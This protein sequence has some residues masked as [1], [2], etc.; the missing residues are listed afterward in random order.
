MK[1]FLFTLAALLMAGS[2]FADTYFYVAPFDVTT[3]QVGT[4]ITVP[5]AAH[6]DQAINAGTIYFTM[7]EGLVLRRIEQ[8]ADLNNLTYTDDWGDEWPA[9]QTVFVANVQTTSFGFATANK[10]Y[11]EVD[12]AWV[13]YG[14]VKL[15][16]GDYTE[17]AKLTIR[18]TDAFTGGDIVTRAELSCGEDA[19]PDVE[20]PVTLPSATHTDPVTFNGGATQPEALTADITI[21]DAD[22]LF[23]P[24]TV[25]NVNDP[26]A[27][28]VVTANDV[29]YPIVDGGITLPEYDTDYHVVVTVTAKGENYTGT[30]DAA[31]D[32]HTGVKP[33]DPDAATPVI[34]FTPNEAGV[35]VNI[36]N[37]TEYTIKVDGD[38][39]D[40]VRTLPYQVNKTHAAQHIEVYAKNAPQ[41]YTAVD[42]TET[43]DLAAL[44]NTP[45]AE[46]TLGET[47]RDANNVYVPVNGNVTKVTVDG[48]EVELVNGEIVL[49]RQDANY[50]P[51]IVIVTNDGQ[52]YD[53]TEVTF[54]NIVVPAKLVAPEIVVD[55]QV[56][57]Q[58]IDP[59]NDGVF[60]QVKGE[61][62]T[63]TIETTYD[64]QVFYTI[65]GSEA[66]QYTGEAVPVEG[67]GTHTVTAYVVVNGE[68][69]PIAEKVITVNNDYTGVNEIANGKAVAGVRYFNMAGQE[70][71]EANG[72]TIV[73]TTY[74][75]GT[76]S[77]VKVMK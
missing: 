17:I 43:Y 28:I 4:N 41:G 65:D 63:F 5:V 62:V 13:E 39:V 54:D 61:V 38:V 27:T 49:P 56:L 71:T 57:T 7:P 75:D 37:Y 21:G 58:W 55:T 52:Y 77:A 2:M 64:G 11:Y 76:T 9:D 73:V 45:S 22:G 32:V 70:M 34:T 12:G 51:V 3:E 46:A 59:D 60:E 31:K 69:T 50:T 72:V 67:N 10:G 6:L 29:E 20:G 35:A 1:K 36:E 26:E 14:A 15:M 42:D 33:A 66:I 44:P 8:G 74:T 25:T 30:V 68:V 24:V 40:Q 48:D 19:R 47:H 16:P 53:D 23:V 18:V